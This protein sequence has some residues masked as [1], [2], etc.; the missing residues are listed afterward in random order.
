ML[1]LVIAKRGAVHYGQTS[2]LWSRLSKSIV[3]CSIVLW[4]CG[5]FRCNFANLSRAA[6]F[7]LERRGFLLATLPNKP[8]LFSLFLIVLS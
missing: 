1:Y 6:M 3:H 5:L 2:P 4:S 8:Y 7:F